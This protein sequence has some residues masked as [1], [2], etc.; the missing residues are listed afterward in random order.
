LRLHLLVGE[1]HM[2]FNDS[3][4][5]LGMDLTRSST[6]QTEDLTAP[7]AGEDVHQDA[8]PEQN[9]LSFTGVHLIVDIAGASRLD[10]LLHVEDTLRQ[11]VEVAGAK[12]LHVHVHKH[13][14]KGGMSGVAILEGSHVSFHSWP[15]A[16]YAA[17]DMVVRGGVEAQ[18]VV[19]VL[20]QSF[21]ARDITVSEH[22]RG[23]PVELPKKAAPRSNV[24][25]LARV[26]KVA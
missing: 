13:A 21:Q 20:R 12:L 11:C 10:D 1:G 22:R 26:R 6:T 2:A 24:T 18:R 15:H 17:F 16:G 8:S 14:P 5:Q 7:L 4:F 25:R 23:G 9:R 3:L 19:D